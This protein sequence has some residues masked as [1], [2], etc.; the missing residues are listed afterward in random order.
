MAFSTI[1][2]DYTGRTTDL[3]ISQGINPTAIGPQNI[4]YSFGAISSYIA[5]V[6]KLVQRFAILLFNTDILSQLQTARASNIQEAVHIFN[7]ASWQ[8]IQ[9][10][11]TYQQ[12][13]PSTFQ[14]EQLATAQLLDIA[15]T[16]GHLNITVQLVT[17][18]G[19]N[20]P[21]I[22]PISI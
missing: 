13:N 17:Q 16:P 4:T 1:T 22:L 15:A 11:K 3:F 5:G 6:Q 9:Q 7:L 14:D 18:A 2:T 21:F 20:F 19:T 8:V 12:Q 10:L